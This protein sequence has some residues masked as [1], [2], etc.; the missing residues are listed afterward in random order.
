MAKFLHQR[1]IFEHRWESVTLAVFFKY[2]NPFSK[3]VIGS[4]VVSRMVDAEG[5]LRTSRILIKV[6][7]L[8][9]WLARFTPNSFSNSALIMEESIV[10]PRVGQMTVTS[11]NLTHQSW[12]AVEERQEFT[13]TDDGHWTLGDVKVKIL[14][15]EKAQSLGRFLVAKLE[16]L[17]IEK[18]KNQLNKSRQALNYILEKKGLL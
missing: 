5:C 13:R 3:H 6:G 8:P 17:S 15:G 7:S 18:F 14:C 11:R 4:D 10:D 16:G 12:M 2:P 9:A 1:N